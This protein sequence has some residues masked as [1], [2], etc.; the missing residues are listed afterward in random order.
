[1]GFD[2][3]T[4]TRVRMRLEEQAVYIPKA[5]YESIEQTKWR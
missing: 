2:W 1:V 5:L 4:S 3:H